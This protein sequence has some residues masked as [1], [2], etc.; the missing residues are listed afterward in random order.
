MWTTQLYLSFLLCLSHVCTIHLTTKGKKQSIIFF[1]LLA[2]YAIK[3]I[4][5]VTCNFHSVSSIQRRL[6]FY[7]IQIWIFNIENSPHSWQM[8]AF[9]VTRRNTRIPPQMTTLT[10]R[11]II[12]ISEILLLFSKPPNR[13]PISGVLSASIEQKKIFFL[14]NSF[15]IVCDSSVYEMVSFTDTLNYI[16][17]KNPVSQTAI[18]GITQLARASVRIHTYI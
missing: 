6:A 2:I 17:Y 3:I 11:W 16:A 13:I 9:N 12:I 8:G 1:K 14:L 5:R 18:A 7:F 10:H 15:W 4:R